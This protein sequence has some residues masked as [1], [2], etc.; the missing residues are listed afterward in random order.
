M[1]AVPRPWLLA[2]DIAPIAGLT[3]SPGNAISGIINTKHVGRIAAIDKHNIVF[4]TLLTGFTTI[5]KS[6]NLFP[7]IGFMSSQNTLM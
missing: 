7:A 4:N 3:I 1:G 2:V 6:I 5:I